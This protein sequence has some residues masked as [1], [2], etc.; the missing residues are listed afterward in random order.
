LLFWGK[1]AGFFAPE[2]KAEA[3]LIQLLVCAPGYRGARRWPLLACLA[4]AL[5]GCGA[6]LSAQRR[7]GGT[8]SGCGAPLAATLM[9]QGGGFAF[10]P[11]D[12]VLVIRGTVAADGTL[13]G[14]LNTAGPGRPPF[15]LSVSGRIVGA[16]A[17]LSY[18][19]PRCT[20]QGTLALRPVRLLP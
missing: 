20:A 4:A 6:P 12:G 18:A 14:R 10:A 7:Y 13:Q 19:T 11:G 1:V 2:A 17:T 5:A 3:K 15:V 9:A 16:A 8:L